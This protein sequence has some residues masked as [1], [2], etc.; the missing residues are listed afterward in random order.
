M[1]YVVM[2]SCWLI[3]VLVI[4]VCCMSCF[5]GMSYGLLCVCGVVVLI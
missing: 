4:V 3:C 5:V 1:M 2:F